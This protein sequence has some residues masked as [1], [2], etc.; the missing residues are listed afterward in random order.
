MPHTSWADAWLDALVSFS[1]PGRMRRGR[2]FA[3]NGFI[4]K[5]DVKPGR[6]TAKVKD[7]GKQFDVEIKFPPLDDASW[8]EIIEKLGS[9]A[10]YSARLLS[11]EMP[12][13]VM[14]VFSEA[15][16]PLFPSANKLATSCTCPD[17]EAPCKHIAGVYY[18]LAD[19]FEKN[20]FLLFYFRGRSK[21]ALMDAIRASQASAQTDVVDDSATFDDPPLEQQIDYFWEIGPALGRITFNLSRPTHPLPHFKRLG[22]PDFTDMDIYTLLK[23]VYETITEKTLSWASQKPGEHYD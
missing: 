3:Q 17:W 18:H 4:K 9:Q 6:I 16:A 15:H 23:P 21:E 20:P 14:D 8:E 5:L 19:K 12:P 2:R 10:L 7:S 1:H 13:E 22:Q 11:G